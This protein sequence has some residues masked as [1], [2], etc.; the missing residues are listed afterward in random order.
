MAEVN[1]KKQMLRDEEERVPQI[2]GFAV[3]E[4][5]GITEKPTSAKKRGRERRGKPNQQTMNT[6]LK[7]QRG[8]YEMLEEACYQTPPGAYDPAAD[9][10]RILTAM[11]ANNDSS[12]VFSCPEKEARPMTTSEETVQFL[13]EMANKWE[14]HTHTHHCAFV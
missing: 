1:R 11:Q 13:T 14:K 7:D 12:K 10:V 6:S 8:K 2:S 9:Y 3:G 5:M 4:K